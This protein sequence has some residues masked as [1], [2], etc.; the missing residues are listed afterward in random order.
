MNLCRYVSLSNN[1]SYS[2]MMHVLCS[3]QQVEKYIYKANKH[4]QASS[5]DRESNQMCNSQKSNTGF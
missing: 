4:L 3:Q 5:Q 2:L 1:A